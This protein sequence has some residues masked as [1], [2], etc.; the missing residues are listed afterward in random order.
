MW[1]DT[2]FCIHTGALVGVLAGL[3]PIVHI[4]K[5]QYKYAECYIYIVYCICYI[6][7]SIA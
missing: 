7:F 3:T 5:L 2:L 4:L 1:G 6:S